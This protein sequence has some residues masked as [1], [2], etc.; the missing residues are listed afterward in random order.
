MSQFVDTKTKT[1]TAAGAIAQNLLVKLADGVVNVAGANEQP[2][3]TIERE[4]F[5][6]GDVVPVSLLSGQ[7][8]FKAV[9]QTAIA[10]GAIVYGTAGGK[11]NVTSTAQIRVGIAMEASS[12]DGDAIEI[13]P[14]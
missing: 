10:Q 3:G 11:V 8:T 2:I 1:F 6:S 5:A 9:A 7:G 4:A 14:G 12:A 13:M